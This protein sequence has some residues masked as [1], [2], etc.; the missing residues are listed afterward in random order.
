MWRLTK[1]G[2]LISH[3]K[4]KKNW[5]HENIDSNEETEEFRV[6]FYFSFAMYSKY[7]NALD[8]ILD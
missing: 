2:W 4:Y 8:K 6:W 1:K 7:F 3:C 5:L